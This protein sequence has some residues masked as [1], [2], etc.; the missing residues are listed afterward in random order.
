MARQ[1]AS[2][3]PTRPPRKRK[4]TA[5]SNFG[6]SRRES[7]DASGFYA[8]FTA[9]TLDLDD[10]VRPALDTDEVFCGDS[11]VD[12][13]RRRQVGRP[14]RHLP[15]VLRRQGVR[16]GPRRGPHPGVL[17][18]LP[19][20]AHP[21]VR[22]VR[23]RAGTGW[24]HRDQRRQPRSQA[25]PVAV[26]RHHHDPPGPPRPVAPGRDPLAEGQ[27]RERQLRLGLVPQA[28]QPGPPRR[29]RAG[30]R[31]V[32]GPARPG[33]APGEAGRRRAAVGRHRHPRRVPRRHPRRVGD[34]HR[35]R[36]PRVPPGAVP[37]RAPPAPHRALHLRGR[38]D[39]RPVHGVGHHGRRC[40]PHRAPLRG[41]RHRSRVRRDRPEAGGGR[42]RTVRRGRVR[43]G[44]QRRRH[45][46]HRRGL[47]RHR[48]RRLHRR[49]R[50]GEAAR[51]ARVRPLARDAKGR[52]YLFDVAG[53]FTVTTNGLRRT[54]LLWR[55]L[56]RAAAIRAQDRS[57]RVIVFT[58]SLPS[59]APRATRPSPTPTAPRWST[60]WC[61]PT[62]R[63]SPSSLGWPP[64]AA[65]ATPAEAG[66]F[67]MGRAGG[68]TDRVGRRG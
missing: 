57:A 28:V 43:A 64:V 20:D 58:S 65:P 48:G 33:R 50:E 3:D 14:R 17:P 68:A 66:P 39:P 6:V 16:G 55:T 35:E 15:A 23:P 25:V 10:E 13:P 27:G 52:E 18:R 51:R 19:R 37:G 41:L 4:P 31:G 61:R 8:R 44:G 42:G 12:A 29:D 59:A 30:H 5:T 47:R 32:E 7:H 22:R 1:P 40:G 63:P 24:P 53:G 67:G 62:P 45:R 21:G 54:D 60:R 11:R 34:A 49:P 36:Q 38:P 46:P 26:G 9:P 2:P 56:G